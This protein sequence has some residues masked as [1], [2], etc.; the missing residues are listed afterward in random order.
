[1]MVQDNKIRL[2]FKYAN[3]GLTAK[4]GELKGFAIA[5]Q[6]M[7]FVWAKAVID[8]SEVVV[9]SPKISRPVAVR[10]GWANNPQCNLYNAFDLPASPFR[11]DQLPGIT[12]GK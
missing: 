5:D 1:M 2:S 9:W 7:K 12:A 3:E 10:Y 6:D 8:G 4:D 11:T